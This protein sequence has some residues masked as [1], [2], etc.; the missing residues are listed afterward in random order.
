M[1][2]LR[3]SDPTAIMRW[4]YVTFMGSVDWLVSSMALTVLVSVLMF[5]TRVLTRTFVSKTRRKN[6]RKRV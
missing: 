1:G 4:S 3:G 6:G 5:V 2:G